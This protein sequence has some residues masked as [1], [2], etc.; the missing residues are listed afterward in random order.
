MRKQFSGRTLHEQPHPRCPTIV[1]VDFHLPHSTDSS[2]S[3]SPASIFMVGL[4]ADVPF[5][6]AARNRLRNTVSARRG[7]DI[8]CIC[9]YIYR[10]ADRTVP[11]ARRPEP[12]ADR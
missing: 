1:P 8:I 10:R 7:L 11:D 5:V 12:P 9:M 2:S 3:F 6:V 4:L